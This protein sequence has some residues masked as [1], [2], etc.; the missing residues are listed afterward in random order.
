MIVPLFSVVH[1]FA[2]VGMFFFHGLLT[3]D[4]D[5]GDGRGNDPYYG[6]LNFNCYSDSLIIM[7]NLLTVNNWV[8]SMLV[9]C[10]RMSYYLFI[11]S[12]IYCR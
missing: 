9:C 12:F 1:I 4:T 5:F 11:I 8:S 10:K 6:L 2:F 3:S 7:V